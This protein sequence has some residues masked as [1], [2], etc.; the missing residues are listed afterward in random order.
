MTGS[1]RSRGTSGASAAGLARDLRVRA[2]HAAGVDAGGCRTSAAS[3]RRG[4]AFDAAASAHARLRKLEL[5]ALGCFAVSRDVGGD[6]PN[7]LVAGD[8]QEGW[9]T[10][11]GFHAGEVQARF[12]LCEF[13]RAMRAYG[14]AT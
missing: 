13:A 3:C 4:A 7:L 14:T 1:W 10:A 2:P 12:V 11:V 9:C 8:H 5:D 6:R